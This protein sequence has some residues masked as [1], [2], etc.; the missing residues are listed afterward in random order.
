MAQEMHL[1]GRPVFRMGGKAHSK[2]LPWKIRRRPYFLCPIVLVC[3]AAVS[4][5]H[6]LGGLIKRN[7][8][9]TVLGAGSLMSRC[10]CLG[11]CFF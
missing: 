4:T 2:T 8:V 6:R 7:V 10:V 11:G 3:R 1:G 5:Y 9:L